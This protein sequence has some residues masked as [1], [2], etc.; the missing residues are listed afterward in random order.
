MAQNLRAYFIRHVVT[1]KCLL[2]VQEN[3]EFPVCH[4]DQA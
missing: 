2:C 1:M 3:I 4:K